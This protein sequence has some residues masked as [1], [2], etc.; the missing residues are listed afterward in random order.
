MADIANPPERL[1]FRSRGRVVAT[2]MA[3]TSV[4]SAT[5]WN[6]ARHPIT[7]VNRPGTKRPLKPP[8]ADPET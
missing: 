7:S 6:A 2:I 3:A 1:K 8:I 5:T 4:S